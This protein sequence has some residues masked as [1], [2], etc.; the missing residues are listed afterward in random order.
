[1]ELKNNIENNNPKI[2]PLGRL[3]RVNDVGI[4][5]EDVQEVLGSVPKW[6]LRWGIS[7][8][9]GIVLILIVGSCMFKYP[10]IVAAPMV[11]TTTNPPAS[12]VARTSAK[13]TKLL[14]ADQQTVL[15]DDCLAILE[16]TADYE[17]INFL[18]SELKQIYIAI[19][20]GNKYDL[21]RKNLKLGVV[22]SGFLSLLMKLET[23]NQFLSLNYYPQKLA[24]MRKLI[25]ANNMHF[26]SL[27]KQQDI[28]NKQHDL[29]IKSHSRVSYLL[30]QHLISEEEGD[31]AQ[32]IL[33]QSEM[34]VRNMKSTLES[35]QIQITQ[36]EDNL[37]ETEQQYI[38]KTNAMLSELKASLTQLENEIRSWEMTY[39]LKTPIAGKVT[40]TNYWN[41]NQNVIAGDIVF[42]IVPDSLLELIG[43]VQL[44]VNRS[45][46]VQ[47]GQKV[48]VHFN[49]YPDSEY[50]IVTARIK[51]ISLIPAREG[52]FVAEVVFPHGLTTSYGKTLALTQEMTATANIITDDLRLIE[53]FIQPLKKIFKNNL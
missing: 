1:M 18:K 8:L 41:A 45:G 44:P 6:I 39:V 4:R 42:T 12:V 21:K 25:D 34:N 27:L 7:L 38:E 11:L 5:S 13:I 35:K 31:K 43:K 2:S 19:E 33:L 14:V 22:Q 32:S 10:D 20:T 24:S 9:A 51:R 40:F 36:L 48:N 23:Y 15:P 50:G 52:Y 47:A 28:V 16:N 37:I 3:E 46:K 26:R 17:N 29:E 53:Q 30:K 49:N